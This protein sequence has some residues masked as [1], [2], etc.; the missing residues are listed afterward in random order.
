MKTT[1]LFLIGSAFAF[2]F[3]AD[4]RSQAN[5]ALRPLLEQVQTLKTENAKLLEKQTATLQK[6][7]EMRLQAQQIK[8]FTKRS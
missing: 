8:T 4:V 1:V 7:E 2:A 6:L 3:T 5:Q